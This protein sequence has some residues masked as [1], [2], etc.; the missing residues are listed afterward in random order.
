MG[1][2]VSSVVAANAEIEN[3]NKERQRKIYILRVLFKI[4]ILRD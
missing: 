3:N 1:L 2:A 4:I